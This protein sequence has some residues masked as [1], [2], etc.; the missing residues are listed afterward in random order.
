MLRIINKNKT[1]KA[2]LFN[3]EECFIPFSMSEVITPANFL[4]EVFGEMCAFVSL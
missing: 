4:V 3:A 1:L 2:N